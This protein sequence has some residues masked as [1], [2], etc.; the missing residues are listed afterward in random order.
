MSQGKNK[1][2]GNHL[3]S[4][5]SDSELSEEALE[6]RYHPVIQLSYTWYTHEARESTAPP[7]SATIYIRT[8]HVESMNVSL[9]YVE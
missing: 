2:V 4:Y 8:I 6:R 1:V 3:F 9:A 5:A 7:A